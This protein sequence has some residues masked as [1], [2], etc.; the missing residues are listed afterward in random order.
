L[1][2]RVASA[3]ERMWCVEHSR[4]HV[5]G[6]THHANPQSSFGLGSSIIRP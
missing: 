2:A 4:R 3:G 1:E 6:H 5:H